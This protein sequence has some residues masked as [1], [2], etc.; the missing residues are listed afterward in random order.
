MLEELEDYSTTP[1]NPTRPFLCMRRRRDSSVRTTQ[2]PKCAYHCAIVYLLST[3]LATR[4]PEDQ[5]CAAGAL[6]R[7]SVA[8]MGSLPLRY[9]RP[10]A[11]RIWAR[12]RQA[13][14]RT[15]R[16]SRIGGRPTR[17]LLELWG[18]PVELRR[19]FTHTPPEIWRRTSCVSCPRPRTSSQPNVS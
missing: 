2:G 13:L 19:C 16:P 8:T 9:R 18:L 4:S 15:W 17:Q 12:R 7:P 6:A 14:P 3:R 5:L 1:P 11:N 10:P